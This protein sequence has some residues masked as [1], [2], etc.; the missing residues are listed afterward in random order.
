[1]DFSKEDMPANAKIV[2]ID[3]SLES[4]NDVDRID[5]VMIK[6]VI[7][8]CAKEIAGLQNK[9]QAV[10]RTFTTEYSGI[11]LKH[12]I[13][14]IRFQLNIIIKDNHM[15]K[16]KMINIH[17]FWDE[18][19]VYYVDN[20]SGMMLRIPVDSNICPINFKPFSFSII[21]MESPN[22]MLVNNKRDENEDDINGMRRNRNPNGTKGLSN[23]GETIEKKRK[24]SEL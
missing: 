6:S 14:H 18:M 21:N 15:M 24:L 22:I 2:D 8:Y 5:W 16:I 13:I 3:F 19:S 12:Y 20:P 7:T 17:R 1:M 11:K 4:M 23:I 9:T 10:I